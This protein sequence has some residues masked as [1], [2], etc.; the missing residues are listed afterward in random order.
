MFGSEYSENPKILLTSFADMHSGYKSKANKIGNKPI[1]NFLI[2]TYIK[3]F[4][5]P[6]IGFQLRSMYFEKIINDKLKRKKIHKILDMGSGIGTYSFWL[7]RRFPKA[8]ITGGEIDESKLKFSRDFSKKLKIDNINFRYLDATKKNQNMHF[9][10][11]INIDVLEHIH[12]YKNVLKN[13]YKIL[14]PKGHLFVHTPQP[15]QKRIFRKLR[16]WRHEDHMH[17]GY[18]P[19]ELN[20]A[21]E[22]LGFKIISEVETF[23]FFGKL[24]WELNHILLRK[25][26]LI[27]GALYPFLFLISQLDLQ[28][29]NK[30]GLGTAI[31]AQKK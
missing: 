29:K 24:S 25:G 1:I 3:I 5:I 18:T 6:E 8:K 7:A 21:L 15:N 23:G 10:L 4:G 20:S 28:F 22:A 17:E 11:I 19:Q 26:F 16:R 9:D 13:F 14:S 27:S 30:N 2:K 12:N 31:L